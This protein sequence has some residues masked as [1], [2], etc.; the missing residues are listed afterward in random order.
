MRTLLGGSTAVLRR[1]VRRA[2]QQPKTLVFPEGEDQRILEACRIMIDERMGRPILLGDVDRI[3]ETIAKQD[4]E[5][6]TMIYMNICREL[7]RRLRAGNE[8]L[9]E[10]RVRYQHSLED[11]SFTI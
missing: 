9:F 8:L 3:R 1:F 7:G 4:I 10:S 5:Q 11:Y 2:Q 6:F